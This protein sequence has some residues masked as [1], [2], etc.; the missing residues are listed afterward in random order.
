MAIPAEG[1]IRPVLQHGSGG[2]SPIVEDITKRYGF[3]LAAE[4]TGFG[5]L[6]RDITITGVRLK[7]YHLDAPRKYVEEIDRLIV[8]HASL[9][10]DGEFTGPLLLESQLFGKG[11]FVCAMNPGRR[12]SIL[13]KLKAIEWDKVM[14]NAVARKLV[15]RRDR[16]KPRG[17]ERPDCTEELPHV[18]E[19]RRS[20]KCDRT[21]ATN[22]VDPPF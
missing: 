8:D 6:D 18:A 21:D 14:K 15:R 10:M 17:G 1:G 16:L 11:H 19:A 2:F 7:N 4:K 5:R 9:A 12:R 22:P 13:G 20:E 3:K